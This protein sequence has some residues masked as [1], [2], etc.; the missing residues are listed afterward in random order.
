MRG[1]DR[2]IPISN[3][4]AAKGIQHLED[5]ILEFLNGYNLANDRIGIANDAEGNHVQG[6]GFW[7]RFKD[8]AKRRNLIMHGGTI[9]GKPEAE[10]S[11]EAT[12]A[13]VAYLKK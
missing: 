9:V 12:S 8:L 11:L 4:F 1:G 13:L 5:T 10:A 7:Q 3:S 2:A 6:E